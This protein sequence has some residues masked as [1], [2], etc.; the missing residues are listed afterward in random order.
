MFV[1]RDFDKATK[2]LFDPS[3]RRLTEEAHEAC[4]LTGIN[5]DELY[6]K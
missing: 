2:R 3:T 1:G 6:E 5:P 4:L